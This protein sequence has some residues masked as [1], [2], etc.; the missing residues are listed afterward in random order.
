M[1]DINKQDSLQQ[2]GINYKGKKFYGGC[3]MGGWTSQEN[4][5][6]VITMAD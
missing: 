1:A 6:I 2:H 5:F 4:Q 3:L